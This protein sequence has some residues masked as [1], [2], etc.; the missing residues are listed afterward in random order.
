MSVAAPLLILLVFGVCL[1]LLSQPLWPGHVERRAEVEDLRRVDLEAARVAKYR[2]IR[3]AELD[4]D[5]GKLSP[6]DWRAADRRLRAEAVA[7]L[8]ELEALGGPATAPDA[9]PAPAA[10]PD[11]RPAR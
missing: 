7:I 6:A 11:A 1:V 2:E 10:A 8:D 5:T 4:R 9:A 3:D